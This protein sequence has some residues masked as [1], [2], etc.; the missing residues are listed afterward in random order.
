MGNNYKA[1]LPLINTGKVAQSLKAKITENL[2]G[3]DL[4]K[5]YH[6]K[7]YNLSLHHYILL[8]RIVKTVR[9]RKDS[10]YSKRR[11]LEKAI[12]LFVD[13]LE[14]SNTK[15]EEL[16]DDDMQEIYRRSLATSTP[17]SK[18]GNEKDATLVNMPVARPSF[19][20]TL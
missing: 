4:K 15:L 1:S 17:A 9:K 5:V 13:Q 3:K 12:E 2:E 14:G 20:D 11:A 8:E 6:T 16:T 19:L 10:F 18:R 7:S